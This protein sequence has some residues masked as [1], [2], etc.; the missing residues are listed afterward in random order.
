MKKKTTTNFK[1]YLEKNEIRRGDLNFGD[2]IGSKK[3]DK[4]EKQITKTKGNR[5]S[6]GY[7]IIA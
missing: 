6:P 4:N 7:R 1:D 3:K 5:R 2:N